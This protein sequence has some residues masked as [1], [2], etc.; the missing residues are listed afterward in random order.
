MWCG[1]VRL[2][3]WGMTTVTYDPFVPGRFAVGTRSF[4][5]P[6]PARDRVLPG[7]IWYPDGQPG[8]FPLVVYSHPVGGTRHSATFLA[9][10]LAGHGYAVAAVDHSEV[11]RQSLP[12]PPGLTDDERLARAVVLANDR[13]PDLRQLLDHLLD[14]SPSTM[15]IELDAGRIGLV[16]HSFGGWTVLATPEVDRRIGAVV[17]L[18][19]GGS[20]NPLP[21]VLPLT[22]TLDWG[23][24]VPTLFLAAEHDVPIPP[25]AVY[26][27][28]RRTQAAKRMLVLRRADH[29]HFVDNVAADHET[30]RTMG[31]TGPA[32]WMP[33]AMRPIDELCPPEEAHTFTRGLTLAHLD[34]ALRKSPD[35]ETFMAGDLVAALAAHGVDAYALS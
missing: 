6:D 3:R 22:L 13:V 2:A 4:P 16:G 24:D 9:A 33:A 31:I 23:R 18:A 11:V 26:D 29:Q 7:E 12:L 17:A 10:H 15:D 27:I 34:A 30:F 19:P 32:A 21:G 20:T 14:G 1:R 25:D 28:Y 8:P 5:V 35:A